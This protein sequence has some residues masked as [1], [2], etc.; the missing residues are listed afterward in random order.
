M[1][2]F[3]TQP[4]SLHA[5]YQAPAMAAAAATPTSRQALYHVPGIHENPA[6]HPVMQVE[7]SGST[8]F[9]GAPQFSFVVGIKGPLTSSLTGQLKH[10]QLC[11]HWRSQD[12]IRTG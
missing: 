4:S 12:Y 9:H 8:P 3:G 10:Q 2:W 6:S 5:Y 1:L 7:A 11:K